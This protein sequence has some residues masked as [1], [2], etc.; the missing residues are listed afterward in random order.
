MSFGGLYISISGIYA[1][2]KSLDTVSHNIA[3]AN[4]KDYVRQSAIHAESRYPTTSTIGLRKGTGVDI[5]QIRQ[6]RDEFLDLR[7]RKEK[8]LYGYFRTKEEMLGE[9]EAIFNE[10]TY[11]SLQNVMDDFWNGWEELYKEPDSLTIRGLLHESAVAFTT[12][13]NHIN[14]QLNNLQFDLNKELINRAQEVNNILK[15][16]VSLNKVIQKAAGHGE[17]ISANDYKD[18]LNAKL[19]RLSEIIPITYHENNFGAVIITLNGRELV[20]GDYYNPLKIEIDERNYGQ[21]HWSDTGELIDLEGKGELGGYVD[22]RDKLVPEYRDR[23][24]ILVATLAEVINAIHRKGYTLEEEAETGLDFFH[25][26]LRE[27]AATIRVNPEL[28]DLSKIATSLTGAKGDGEIARAILNLRNIGL[29]GRYEEYEGTY[30]H[31]SIVN[32]LDNL[33]TIEDIDED[34]IYPLEGLGLSLNPDE[35]YKE[36]ILDLSLEREEAFNLADN[37]DVLIRQLDQRREE[38]S[39][40]S[41]D[42]EMANMIKYQHSYVANS[43]VIN[44]IDEMIERIINGIGVTR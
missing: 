44:A 24:N 30:I 36:T 10:M 2:K 1:N 27:P 6:I 37:Q 20:N 35:F 41:L 43:R 33:S 12:T 38:I 40:V 34:I 9:I 15:E 17:R 21:I 22:A 26:E 31:S 8:A 11:S 25:I 23:L 4:N 18:T 16:I 32:W 42:E 5:Q 19:D 29:Y 39:G 7:I 28:V 3:N 14:S 13:V